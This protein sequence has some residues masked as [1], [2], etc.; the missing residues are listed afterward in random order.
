MPVVT[1]PKAT[2]TQKLKRFAKH[3]A[4]QDVKAVL[5]GET[6]G[7]TQQRITPVDRGSQ[8]AMQTDHP[9]RGDEACLEL[10]D[11]HGLTEVIVGARTHALELVSGVIQG[12]RQDEIRVRLRGSSTSA[13]LGTFDARHPPIANHDVGSL[14]PELSPR[15]LAVRTRNE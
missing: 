4:H 13:Q 12:R 5:T 2:F 15:R 6:P 7:N 1:V 10:I 9:L 14:D 11:R 8:V 3:V